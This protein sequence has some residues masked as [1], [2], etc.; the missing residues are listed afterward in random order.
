MGGVG[1][2]WAARLWKE[3]EPD[4]DRK[5]TCGSGRLRFRLGGK[6]VSGAGTV[7][8]TVSRFSTGT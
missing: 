5:W 8:G 4:V 1:E 6:G 3:V 2:D 7:V